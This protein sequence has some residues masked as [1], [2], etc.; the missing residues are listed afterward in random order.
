MDDETQLLE[1]DETL[2]IE[3]AALAVT[4]VDPPEA[5][6]LARPQLYRRR[7]VVRAVVY[8]GMNR[9]DMVTE[10]GAYVVNEDDALVVA[11]NGSPHRLFPGDVCILRD[12][13]TGDDEKTE[14]VVG[15]EHWAEG[16]ELA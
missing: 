9:T 13:P 8:T 12:A 7:G 1:V 10:A 4:P 16:F 15:P 11:V 3:K 5:P 6:N 2:S 14:G